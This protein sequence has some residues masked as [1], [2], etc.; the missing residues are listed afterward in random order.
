MMRVTT[1]DGGLQVVTAEMPER[2]SVAVGV[3]LR[4][5]SRDEPARLNGI[6]HFVEHLVFKGTRRRTGEQITREIEGAGG[7]INASTGEES[8]F[9]HAQVLP[10][11]LGRAVDILFDMVAR[12]TFR[13]DQLDVQKD[14]VIEEIRMVEDQPA[15]LVDDLFSEALWGRHPLARRITGTERSVRGI[16]RGDIVAYHRRMYTRGAC[17][18]ALAG[19]VC[20]DE[21]VERVRAATRGVPAGGR[22]AFRRVAGR[23]RAPRVVTRARETEEAHVVLGFPTFRRDHPWRF[24]LKII[25]TLLGENMS[26]RLFENVREKRGLAYS[27]RSGIDRYVDTG[28]FYVGGGFDVKRLSLALRAIVRELDRLRT[29]RVPGAELDRAKQYALGQFAMALER[30]MTRMVWMGENVL[31]SGRLPDEA[32]TIKRIKAVSADDVQR[33]A[34]AVFR[35]KTIGAAVIWPARDE[36]RLA[37]YLEMKER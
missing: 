18:V 25:S 3:W 19:K 29:K 11:N 9:Y 23:R 36:R 35:P 15:Y 37:R 26:S 5:G 7:S 31:L 22:R 6:S 30:S 21:A 32:E 24:G 4:C 20:H 14:I 12:P 27:I 28:C 8:T 2:G 13:A 16:C 33:I 1:L 17:V 34:R 10:E